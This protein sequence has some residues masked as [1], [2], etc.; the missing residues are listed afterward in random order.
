MKIAMIR[1]S[2]K[3]D[4]DVDEVI[5]AVR[6]FVGHIAAHDPSIEYTSFCQ[7]SPERSFTH[8]GRFPSE[9][10]TK[11]LQSQEFFG[12]FAPFLKERCAEGPS[13]TWLDEVA[14]TRR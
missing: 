13:V 11:S 4:V 3:A 10:V 1:Y 6:E 5:A 9:E 12:K 14:T 7:D 2:L 8:I